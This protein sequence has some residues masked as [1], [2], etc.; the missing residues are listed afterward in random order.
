M[1]PRAR[2]AAAGFLAVV[3]GLLAPL[4][5]ASCGSDPRS[6]AG[7]CKLLRENDAALTDTSDPAGLAELYQ[8]LDERTPL[9]I[10]D[11]WHTVSLLMTRMT[12]FN[13]KSEEDT[14][15]LIAETLSAQ[16][17]I[18]AVGDWADTTCKVVL[19]TLTGDTFD[20]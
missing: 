17:A 15:K 11:Q 20:P 5:L 19:G 18:K 4:A 16:A 12:T 3:A 8:R 7:F 6:I 13:P 10:K 1:T 2:A 9:Q 14:Q